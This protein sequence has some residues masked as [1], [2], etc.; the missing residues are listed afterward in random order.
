MS[1]LNYTVDSHPVRFPVVHAVLGVGGHVVYEDTTLG[2]SWGFVEETA[3]PTLVVGVDMGVPGGDK[4][5]IT[6]VAVVDGVPV[7][8]GAS[9]EV[10]KADGAPEAPVAP[11]PVVAEAP[12][13]SKPSG[14]KPAAL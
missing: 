4:A 8:V 10:P 2:T 11:A 14:K 5:V 7:V 3:A 9:V 12:A 6:P 1:S 13:A